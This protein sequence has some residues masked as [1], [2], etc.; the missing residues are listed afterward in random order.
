MQRVLGW[1][2][3]VCAAGMICGCNSGGH[4]N[5]NA[6]DSRSRM[7]APTTQPT[8]LARATAEEDG[9]LPRRDFVRRFWVLA[10]VVV[11][12]NMTWHF[13][14]AWM[15]P[16]LQEQHGYTLAQMSWFSSGYYIATDAGALA[17][18]FAALALA[19]RGLCGASVSAA[20][21][22]AQRLG[23]S[24]RVVTMIPDSAERYLSKKIFEGGI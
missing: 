3:T 15:P 10:T 2:L 5:T 6:N 11:A 22:V 4:D 7:S 18:G 17:M 12:I 8:E 9:A 16:F 21:K 20:V 19:R 23:P 13:F 24:K 14:R 1:I